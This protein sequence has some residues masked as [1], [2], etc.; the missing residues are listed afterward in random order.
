MTALGGG[1]VEGHHGSS[2]GYLDLYD[3]RLQRP[4]ARAVIKN[5]RNVGRRPQE[6]KDDRDISI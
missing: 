6:K 1:R 4:E 5:R 2:A 3:A